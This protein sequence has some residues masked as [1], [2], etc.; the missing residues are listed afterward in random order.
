MGIG[1]HLLY[2]A[3]V[4]VLTTPEILGD[5]TLEHFQKVR[6][7]TTLEMLGHKVL[8]RDY[9]EEAEKAA[10]L[11]FPKALEDKKLEILKDLK[12]AL[13]AYAGGGIFSK[14]S[15]CTVE[16]EFQGVTL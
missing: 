10:L 14:S 2:H 5:K 4:R 13:E 8:E 7:L 6:V 12:A 16:L 11:P 9:D 3:K 1:N 15:G